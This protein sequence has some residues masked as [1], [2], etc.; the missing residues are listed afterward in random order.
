MPKK[1]DLKY[2]LEQYKMFAEKYMELGSAV[3]AAEFFGVG[4][5][6]VRDAVI[7]IGGNRKEYAQNGAKMRRGV[8]LD[9]EAEIVTKYRGG[10]TYSGLAKEYDI[11]ESSIRECIERS[12]FLQKRRGPTL[13][14]DEEMAD[15]IHRLFKKNCT[16]D[17]I[18]GLLGVGR[19]TVRKSLRNS[20]VE[21]IGRRKKSQ[22]YVQKSGYAL[23]LLDEKE[24]QIFSSMCNAYGYVL[25]HRHVVA[26]SIGRSLEDHE[27]VHHKDGDKLNNKIENLQLMSGR[28]GK[29]VALRCRCCGSIDIQ[30]EEIA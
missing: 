19:N 20:G 14:V 18:S 16:V 22:R 26:K 3:K 4:A 1:G 13:K 6:Y 8:P 2:T 11:S 30:A 7:R 25:E 17:L 10:A 21:Y 23:V 29:G 15:A 24:R 28:H 27:T 9:K 12:G 5:Y